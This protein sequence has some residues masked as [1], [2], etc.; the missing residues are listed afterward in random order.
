[1]QKNVK[2]YSKNLAVS[3]IYCNFA[4]TKQHYLVTAPQGHKKQSNMANVIKSA[5]LAVN[6]KKSQLVIDNGQM[7]FGSHTAGWGTN[8]QE[9][10][11]K[12]GWGWKYV[13]RLGATDQTDIDDLQSWAQ[14]IGNVIG[15]PVTSIEVRENPTP[16]PKPAPAQEQEQE[17]TPAPVET[18]APAQ[19]QEHA[20]PAE[21]AKPKPAPIPQAQ[22]APQGDPSNVLAG[23]SN[24]LASDVYNR[25]LANLQPVLEQLTQQAAA[26]AAAPAQ[27]IVVKTLDGT[28]HNVEGQTH[29]DFARIL[30]IVANNIPVLLHGE[31]GTGKTTLAK[32]IA[33]A[34]GLD[35]YKQG[36]AGTKYDYTGYIDANGQRVETPAARAY[37][38]GGLLL[39][40][41]IFASDPQALLAINGM[42]DGDPVEFAGELIYPH[43]NFRLVCA[44]NTIGMGATD[45]YDRNE[46]DIS[47]VN[48]LARVEVFADPNIELANCGG[49]AALLEYYTDLKKAVKTCGVSLPISPRDMRRAAK[50]KLISN[51]DLAFTLK[52][53]TLSGLQQD[54]LRTLFVNLDHKENIWAQAHKTLIGLAA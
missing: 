22:T 41:E 25:V 17:P 12:S 20:A 10:G 45:G 51:N 4:P 28:E 47:F 36:F 26:N 7:Y 15:Q 50:I 33:Q 44:D 52:T 19:E 46:Q 21:T 48:G 5:I 23:L 53:S 34:L 40:D 49:D 2:K 3:I 27:Q 42:R 18:P 8:P 37:K 16:K 31:A 11:I 24:F 13:A 38:Y 35:F 32:Q 29:K 6:G 30:N 54:I 9:L 14:A 39:L 1:M 43:K